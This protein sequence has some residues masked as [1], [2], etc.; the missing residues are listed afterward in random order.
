[1]VPIE[2]LNQTPQFIRSNIQLKRCY[3]CVFRQTP[4]SQWS[5]QITFVHPKKGSGHWHG[6]FEGGI[7]VSHQKKKL[8]VKVQHVGGRVTNQVLFCPLTTKMSDFFQIILNKKSVCI[9]LSNF[10]KFTFEDK[11]LGY[12]QYI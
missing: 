11:N 10:I 8:W 12:N 5:H 7:T 1:M 6:G 9:L 2:N 3:T 4:Y